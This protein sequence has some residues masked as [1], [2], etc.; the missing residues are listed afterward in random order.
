MVEKLTERKCSHGDKVLILF[1]LYK[2]KAYKI[3]HN[4]DIDKQDNNG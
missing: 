1:R 4:Y 3:Y 2:D